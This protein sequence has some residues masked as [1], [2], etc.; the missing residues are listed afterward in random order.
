MIKRKE[1]SNENRGGI[2]KMSNFGQAE[3]IIKIIRQLSS[4]SIWLNQLNPYGKV[5]I[6]FSTLIRIL[7]VVPFK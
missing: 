1:L 6:P 4:I 5:K 2:G 3:L 7:V